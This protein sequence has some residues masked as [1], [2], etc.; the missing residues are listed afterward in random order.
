MNRHVFTVFVLGLIFSATACL[1]PIGNGK[2]ETRSYDLKNFTKI[3]ACDAF[4]V[5]VT[6]GKE[7]KVEVTTD[8]NVFQQL[9]VQV[10]SGSLRLEIGGHTFSTNRL[11][12]VVTLPDLQGIWAEDA[13]DVVVAGFDLPSLIVDAQD[14]CQIDLEKSVVNGAQV[15]LSDASEL[16]LR[17]SQVGA[18]RLSGRLQ[19]ASTL[20]YYGLPASV[21][22]SCQDA[23]RC[24]KR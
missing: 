16:I 20:Y 6:Q 1:G 19:D 3:E 15:N 18:G 13:V 10:I 11:D 14:A 2:I 4:N 23:S 12:A 17:F 8:E 22:V 21:D 7:F 5:Y 9:R 24:I